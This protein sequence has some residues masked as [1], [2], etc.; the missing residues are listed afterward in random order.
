MTRC[1]R[2]LHHQPCVSS[3]KRRI[4][5]KN[6]KLLCAESPR[7]YWRTSAIARAW[8]PVRMC[9]EAVPE[10]IKVT[11]S[12]QPMGGS[13]VKGCSVIDWCGKRPEACLIEGCKPRC[14]PS[15]FVNEELRSSASRGRYRHE[16]EYFS[17]HHSILLYLSVNQPLDF[18]PRQNPSL[19]LRTTR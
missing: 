11:V 5:P 9:N 4:V 2:R 3:T 1:D 15:C 13:H 8:R 14:H 7:V 19:P 16:V 12:Q 17:T 18:E 10:H 6:T